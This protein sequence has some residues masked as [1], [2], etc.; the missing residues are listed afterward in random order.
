ME[1]NI[2]KG[3]RVEGKDRDP[4]YFEL[5]ELDRMGDVG[6]NWERAVAATVP[7]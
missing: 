1:D 4:I 3:V 2:W 6:N 5:C 7:H